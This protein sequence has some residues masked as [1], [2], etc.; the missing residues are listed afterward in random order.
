MARHGLIQA[1]HK[2]MEEVERFRSKREAL[3]KLMREKRSVLRGAGSD[4]GSA[5]KE[6]FELGKKIQKL[7][8]NASPVRVRKRCAMTGRPRGVFLG[9]S[10]TVLREATFSGFLPGMRRSSW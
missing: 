6:I 1:N 8:R 4:A 2:K 10:R 9:L 3:K 5:R 7:P